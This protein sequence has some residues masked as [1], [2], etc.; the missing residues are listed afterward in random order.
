MCGVAGLFGPGW[1][2]SQ[3]N[4][5]VAVQQH[6][7]P[8]NCG[9][10]VDDSA[11]G[12]LG[13]TRLS[14]L[15][16]TSAGDQPMSNATGE[17]QVVFNGEIYNFLE[18][19]REL[20]DYR[21]RT[22]TDTEVIL[23]AYE[24][25]GENCLEHFF[26]MFAFL[27]W[28]LRERR[29]FAARDRFG[30]KPLYYA[31][32]PDGGLWLASEIRALHAAGIPADINEKTWATYLA[33]GLHDHSDETFWMG[34]SSLAPGH[35]LSW[36]KRRTQIWRWYDL[37]E[38]TGPEFD[39][40]PLEVVCEE[41][42]SLLA[43]SVRLRF[44]SDV[45][46]GINISGGLDSSTL[47]GLVDKTNKRPDR[48]KA[49]TYTTGDQQYDELPWVQH[50]LQ[51]MWHPSVVYQLG[52]EEIPNLAADVQAHED[53]PFGGLPTLAYARLFE[54]SRKLGVHVLLD[55]Q[56][57]DE[58]WAGYDYYDRLTGTTSV[59]PLQGTKQKAVMPECL[60]LEFLSHAVAFDPQQPFP[61]TLRNRQYLDACYTKMPRA[62]R[63]ND[64]VSMR[65]SV[66]LREPFLDHRLFEIAVRQPRHRKIANGV[67]KWMLRKITRELLPC[68]VVEA[69]KR[70][71]Q[72]PQREWLVGPLRDWA[73]SCIDT[74]LSEYR[75]AW[76]NER[77][78]VDAWNEYCEGK[79]TNSFYVWQWI[80]LGLT[81]QNSG[82]KR[83]RK[84]WH[85]KLA[86]CPSAYEE[87]RSLA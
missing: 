57:M 56:G 29:L 69:P 35:A 45:E 83:V 48:V 23:G 7:G 28:D 66:E 82:A 27:I 49:F 54:I 20:H 33:Y 61:D 11:E 32:R 59:A 6:R 51:K 65:A 30:V 80:S 71:V 44:R 15:D 17:L 67:R 10:F 22:N 8:D 63:F 46:V 40:R 75:G 42:S 43:E 25:W 14:I 31:I 72:T 87:R 78:V 36:Q 84:D 55:G 60:T 77:S 70:P 4:S 3:L 24:R 5:M 16:L 85:T 21:F 9:I 34:I 50:M 52:P 41:Y 53:E 81:L 39:D 19:R 2:V 1:E 76:F 37:A 13:H 12:G 68:E 58:Q 74:G 73:R 47:L 26:G 79:N 62:L 86:A 64:R 18:L 38:R